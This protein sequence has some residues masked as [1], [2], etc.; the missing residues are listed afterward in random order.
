[1]LT[2]LTRVL[3]HLP[4]VVIWVM[5]SN[6]L[7]SSLGVLEST[8]AT[9][10]DNLAGNVQSMMLTQAIQVVTNRLTEAENV[11]AALT[12]F[13]KT[14][15]VLEMDL[16]PS[17]TDLQ[18]EIFDPYWKYN[19]GTL[20][21]HPMLSIVS[22]QGAWLGNGEALAT[23]LFWLTWLSMG[24]N[25]LTNRPAPHTCYFSYL[26]TSAN[27][28]STEMQTWCV[29]QETA[30]RVYRLQDT[31][32][33]SAAFTYEMPAV[34]Q[35]WDTDLGFDP[36]T[37][38][39]ELGAWSW[40]PCK[41]NTWIEVAITMDASTMSA[42]LAAQLVGS[43]NDRLFI[44]W[45]QPHGHMLAASNG[46]Y[47]SQSN[48]DRSMINPLTD[49]PNISAY[50]LWTCLNAT[51]LLIRSS[52][53]ELWDTYH[54]WTAIPDLRTE[55]TLDGT[56][57]W[58]AVGHSYVGINITIVMLKNLAAVMG[59]IDASQAAVKLQVSHKKVITYIVLGAVTV[60]AILL[61][62]T[63]GVWL[64]TRLLGLAA[65]MD[66][67]ARLQFHAV[68]APATVF[69]E[70]HRFQTSFHKMERGLQA[71][72][73]FVPQAV[74][75]VL[76]A[77]TMQAS[78]HMTTQ[79]MTIM[80]ADIE[81]FS[82]VCET[83]PAEELAEVCTEYFELMCG[84]LAEHHGTIDK[85]IGDCIMGLWNAPTPVKRHE[86]HAVR[87]ALAMQEGVL[88]LHSSWRSRRLP[89]LK[90]RLG[91]HTGACLV[92][93]FGCSYRVSYTCLGDSVNLAARLEA[94]NKK[95]G[96]YICISHT[97]YEGCAGGFQCRRLAKVTVP[98]KAEVL[99]V[100]E[101]LCLTG[102]AEVYDPLDSSSG[103]EDLLS[104][105]VGTLT[106]IRLDVLIASTEDTDPS[107]PPGTTRP[108]RVLPAPRRD[109]VVVYHWQ[110]VDRTRVLD[111]TAAYHNA[112]DALVKGDLP[113]ARRWLSQRVFQGND[114]AWDALE[115]QLKQQ[116]PGALWNGVFYFTEK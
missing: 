72:S 55:M 82:T 9:S 22:L 80:F 71:F 24:F 57:Y 3:T 85:F 27:L 48:V 11:Q 49:P 33:P 35:G 113:G 12:A 106:A 70:L 37:G 67:I 42:E 7:D 107:G 86:Q 21:G 63:L 6:L 110:H 8:T 43:P 62:L 97:T 101:V 36:I 109:D 73:S 40:L 105:P 84:I 52:C 115:A 60:F 98:G 69:Y 39:V 75:K 54:S 2:F 100:Y 65:E 53:W 59:E 79:T 96:T 41:N 23:R 58:V 83:I 46:M 19:F 61:P 99:P 102:G 89:E 50:V 28:M 90:F 114:K 108:L 45:N 13:I 30:A 38:I 68:A 81:G 111:Y 64:G 95:F 10:I 112:Y 47:W 88:S 93:N 31:T 1:V 51:D 25:V 91:I 17:S 4:A 94:L 29:N 56:A 77:G 92:G 104:S 5:F 16:R 26:N 18:T 103:D 74:V 15:P 76:M 78:Q 44:L 66:G 14:T 20:T 87:A 116:P 34:L 32:V